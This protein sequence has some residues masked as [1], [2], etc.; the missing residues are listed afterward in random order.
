MNG[1]TWVR[2]AT[3]CLAMAGLVS[4]GTHEAPKHDESV[5]GALK[6]ARSEVAAAG[7]ARIEA[8]SSTGTSLSSRSVGVLR[9]SGG[10]R[11]TLRVTTTGGS[12][13]S[14]TRLMGGSPSQSRFLPDAYY[15][16]M[17]DKFAALSDGKHWIRYPYDS[18]ADLSPAASLK[19]LLSSGDAREV[20]R[21]TVRG[22]RATHYTGSADG[23]RVDVWIDHGHLLVK[24]V[25][26]ADT[27]SGAF[28]GTVHYADYGARAS[29]E[30]P[31]AGDTVDFKDVVDR[32]PA[33]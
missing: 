17:T 14:T 26:R 16:R 7:S 11:G 31:P 25:Q 2:Y 1:R 5:T 24:R 12:M 3:V 19:L 21:E 6:A 29:A 28:S 4:C 20:G 8:T 33:S 32:K 27:A 23:Q 9:W 10:L 15:T 18:G 22:V 30:R 13:A